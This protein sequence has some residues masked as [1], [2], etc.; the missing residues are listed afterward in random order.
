MQP[1]NEPRV[2]RTSAF[3][4]KLRHVPC[5]GFAM[6]IASGLCFATASITVELMQGDDGNG[7]DASIVVAGRYVLTLFILRSETWKSVPR[8]GR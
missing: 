5:L 4:E 2:D 7:I 1:E 3:V 8:T 6:A